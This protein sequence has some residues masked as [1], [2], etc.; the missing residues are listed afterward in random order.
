M[1]AE[2]IVSLLPDPP[3][4]HRL[5]PLALLCLF[6][7]GL[8]SAAEEPP[9][10][11]AVA[12]VN[13]ERITR[14]EFGRSLVRSLGRSA[15]GSYVDRVLIEQAARRRGIETTEREV[16]R[17]RELEVEM[18]MRRAYLNARMGPAEFRAVARQYGLDLQQQR[19][20][21]DQSV[22]SPAMRVRLLVEKMLEPE[23]DLG[24]EALRA[25]YRRTRGRRYTAAHV[26]LPRR[27]QAERLLQ[28]LR[29]RPE[30]WNEA[31]RQVSQDRASVPHRGRIGPVPAD[32][33]LGRKLADMQ[34]EEPALWQGER[35]WHVLRKLGEIPPAEEEFQQV[36]DRVRRE[37][38]AERTRSRLYGLTARLRAESTIVP[39]LSYRPESRRVLGRGVAAY[40]NGEAV[41]VH[42][43]S[44]ALIREFGPAVVQSYVERTLLLQRARR[45]GLTVSEEQMKER[46][47]RVAGQLFREQAAER[48]L[49]AEQF[50]RRLRGRGIERR[51][52]EGRLVEEFVSE[53]DVRATLLAEEMVRDGVEV[54]EQDVRRAWERL[55]AERTAVRELAVDS[56]AEAQRLKAR[57]EEGASFDLLARAEAAQP[58]VWMESAGVQEVTPDHPYFNEVKEL[59]QGDVSDVFE[60]GG[61]YR[62]L[63]VVE[64]SAGSPTERPPLESVRDD[65]EKEV[66]LRKARRRIRALLMKMKA[67]SDIRINLG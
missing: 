26:A 17:R 53:Q 40:V 64:R 13:G 34:P 21:L 28:A 11:E 8:I 14:R 66:F 54:T 12:V 4:R 57:L 33:E 5:W 16:A 7:A 9:P 60:Q 42:Q 43:F 27:Q 36:R 38:L 65:L 15:L 22:G 19:R 32:S 24:E 41:P 3:A 31:V 23:L 56:R 29:E 18:R 61:K 50:A 44:E 52:F 37:L 1:T 2:S 46:L 63:K 62:I 59:E 20:R 30:L 35:F 58:G 49:T 39:N 55:G 45:R 25:Y 67:E 51:D 6:S 48:G 10:A 47:E